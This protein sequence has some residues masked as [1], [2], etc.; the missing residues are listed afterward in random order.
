MN[1]QIYVFVMFKMKYAKLLSIIIWL[2]FINL[3]YFTLHYFQLFMAIFN[4][5]WLFLAISPKV[6]FG[7]SRLLLVILNYFDAWKSLSMSRACIS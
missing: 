1:F 3:N 4:Y 6:S 7:Y 5:F 2:F